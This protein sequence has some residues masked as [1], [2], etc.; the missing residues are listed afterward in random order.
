MK[1][2]KNAFAIIG[3]LIVCSFHTKAQTIST[4]FV[5]GAPFCA[6]QTIGVKFSFTGSF[7]SGNAFTVELSDATGDFTSPTVIGSLIGVTAN[8]IFATIPVSTSAGTG[9]R[10]RVVANDPA[11]V[12]SNSNAFEIKSVTLAPVQYGDGF[13]YAHVYNDNNFGANVGYFQTGASLN[14]KTTDYYATSQSPANFGGFIGCDNVPI[15][16][17][18]MIFKRTNFACGKYQIN[19]NNYDD[20]LYI[21]IDGVQV[22]TTTSGGVSIP[23]AWQGYLGPNSQ[24]EIRLAEFFGDS[25]L[26][27][28]LIKLNGFTNTFTLPSLVPSCPGKSVSLNVSAPDIAGMTY[29]W[30]PATG[31]STTAGASVTAN[32]AATTTY[33]VMGT[34]AATGCSESKSVTVTINNIPVIAVTPASVSMCPGETTT[35]VASGANT[36]SWSPATGL[37]M[38]TGNTVMA[39]PTTT[40]TYTV[41]GTNACGN[42]SSQ[43]VTIT[44]AGTTANDNVFGNGE[45]R[46]YC[47]NGNF[48]SLQGY[49]TEPNL[50]FDSKNR[51]P[52][53]GSPA[54]ALGYSGCP[55]GD[56]NH[57]VSYKRTNFTCGVYQLDVPNHDDQ[58]WL[59][60]NGV[61]VATHGGCCDSHTAVWTGVLGPS[62]TVEFRWREGG[63]HSNGAL[64][65]IPVELIAVN[66]VTVCASTPVTLTAVNDP[67][68]TYSWSPATGLNNTN[69]AVVT[70]TTSTTAT[71]TLTVTKDGCTLTDQIT[72]NIS[73]ALSLNVAPI[74]PNI[75]VGQSTTLVAT[76]AN[77]YS[78]S[79]AIGLNTTTGGTVI[80]TPATTTTYTVTGSDGCSVS[81]ATVTVTVGVGDPNVFGNGQWNV[82]CY[83]GNNFNN[84]YGTYTEPNLN[85]DSRNRWGLNNS[86]SD[87][88]GYMGCV[89]PVD[90]HSVSYKRT[91]FTC[92]YYQ[93]DITNH[94]DEALL[95]VDGALVFNHGGC[96]DAHPN[97]W[98]GFLGPTSKV[99][100]RWRE[101]GGGSHGGITLTD[102]SSSVV[103]TSPDVTICETS[104]TTLTTS[105]AGVN[106]TWSANATYLDL[107]ASTGS[108]VTATA[109]MGS[110]GVR[111]VTCTATDPT[112]G[113]QITRKINIT[114]DPL[115]NTQVTAPILTIC[116]GESVILTATGANTYSWF[117]S[118]TLN[119]A[120]GNIVTATPTAT[121]TYTVAGN[122]NCN[123]KNAQITIVVNGPTLADTEF[124]NGKWNVFC[125]N[126]RNLDQLYG[127]YEESSLSFDTRSRWNTSASPSD[128]SGYVGCVLPND[129]HSFVYKRT[130][131]P[132]GFYRIDIPNHDDDCEL[133]IDGVTVFTDNSCCDSHIGVWTGLLLPSSKVE[134][135]VKEGGGNSH[136]GLNIGFSQATATTFIWTGEFNSDWFNALNW[137]QGVPTITT[138]VIIP[139]GGVT[140]WPVINNV[141]AVCKNLTIETGAGLTINAAY[142]LD[143]HGSWINNGG[144]LALNNSTV[145]LRGMTDE[146]IGGSSTTTF[147]NLNIFKTGQKITLQTPI[148]INNILTL[149]DTELALN[150]HKL[151]INNASTSAITR[152]DNGFIN[153]EAA[154]GTNNSIVSW[155]TGTN[156]AAYV[157]PFG[158]SASSYIPVTFN[159][160]SNAD[161]TI[162]ISTRGT[163]VD[164]LPYVPGV[165]LVGVS[166]A[167]ATTVIDRWWDISSSV[168]PLPAPGADITL[169]YQG[170]ENTLP[171]P[172]VDLAIQHYNA[173]LGDWDSPY[174]NSSLGTASGVGSVTAVDV[175]NFSPHVISMASKPLPADFIRF[176]ATVGSRKVHLDWLVANTQNIDYFSVERSDNG[177]RYYTVAKVS[178]QQLTN[179]YHWTDNEPL[180]DVS[181]YRVAQFNKNESFG[182]STVRSVRLGQSQLLSL[183]VV[184]NPA[185][186]SNI[187]L[188]LQGIQEQA[189]VKVLIYNAQGSLV[190]QQ[191]A[192]VKPVA[193][194]LVQVKP[195][196]RLAGGVYFVQTYLD[197]KLLR[198]NF[199]VGD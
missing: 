62:S 96:C 66:N 65:I 45:W 78:W 90:Q 40:T 94:D 70:A 137:C 136:G 157:F 183:Q 11:I 139:G 60:V 119:T 57:A 148:G 93:I 76:G 48:A 33:T 5:P 186:G 49:Y 53:T 188:Q 114:I 165:T 130:N 113:C 175:T 39:N 44:V 8:P 43:A 135:I 3:F 190:H 102:I 58:Y 151:S 19:V 155:Y 1:I 166:G 118:A 75:C 100:F 132:C 138:D 71:Y 18:S 31:L 172:G 170:S 171:T 73:N 142:T 35:L 4:F 80:A 127:H 134:F 52:N 149:N 7:N 84:Y 105:L 121:T 97:A 32:P 145:N 197:G 131:F 196:A 133:K 38:T 61:E 72:V 10:V 110:N 79:P 176:Q 179:N 111:T 128:A 144:A 83:D 161:A 22:V 82:Y 98:Q 152:V 74:A 156:I 17:H 13:W 2:F 54:D 108:S 50:S 192:E 126:G 85:F 153:S 154:L 184:P 59:Y 189:N 34:D 99:E 141:G 112:T 182:Y 20:R 150:Q 47:Y 6:G 146:A 191:L 193:T 194:Q 69:T 25:E 68:A 77:T 81:T 187:Q 26:D 64:N 158:V 67:T 63:G 174:A 92:G 125:Y 106:Y 185:N 147:Y 120:N 107:S 167:D 129:Q 46:A 168:N 56:D 103:F 164:N 91:N 42:S 178:A 123:T 177:V 162:S 41:T 143:V 101:G 115:A 104:S 28:E 29:T 198:T 159:K 86:P 27:L 12:G 24:V 195:K 87:A 88:S 37:N 140:N 181:Y 55:V 30:S 160:K 116:K 122:N 16:N 23:N 15:N 180:S 9:Y 14:I 124:G 109:K 169:S 89:I 199:M 51:W 36:Y 95:Y 117:P 173:T 163:A 21:Y